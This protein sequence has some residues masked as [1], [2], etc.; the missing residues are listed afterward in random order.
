[1]Y[2]EAPDRRIEQRLLIETV[3]SQKLPQSLEIKGF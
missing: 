1:M 2:L 3:S